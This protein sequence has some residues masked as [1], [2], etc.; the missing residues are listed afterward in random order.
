MSSSVTNHKICEKVRKCTHNQKKNQLNRS[1]NNRSNGINRHSFKTP[2]LNIF[3]DPKDENNEE[4]NGKYQK[5][6]NEYIEL[7]KHC[8]ALQYIRNGKRKDPR[9][10][11]SICIIF[12]I[13][14]ICH[15]LILKVNKG[16]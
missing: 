7:R 1:G 9:L 2:I 14:N 3:K 11:G 10:G 8:I 6:P 15:R 12:H 16:F 13:C 5:E 4:R